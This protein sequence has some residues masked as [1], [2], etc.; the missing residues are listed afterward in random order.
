MGMAILAIVAGAQLLGHSMFNYALLHTSATTGSVLALL[1]VP[2]A[3]LIAWIWLGQQPR[4]A[5]L[6]GL[7]VVL[8]GV[9][10]VVLGTRSGR[11]ASEVT[12]AP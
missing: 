7:A 8:I 12:P 1:E 6:I 3:T 4:P 5:T 11:D 2:G 9:A 10:V